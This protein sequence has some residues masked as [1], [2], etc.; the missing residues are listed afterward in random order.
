MTSQIGMFC[1]SGMTKEQV[2]PL[3][4][5][6]ETASVP[7]CNRFRAMMKPLSQVGRLRDEFSIYLTGDGR[8][9]MAGLTSSNI[10]YVASAIHEVTK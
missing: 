1:F 6:D 8:I 10:S 9:S 2:K 4:R 3:S 5:L 7:R